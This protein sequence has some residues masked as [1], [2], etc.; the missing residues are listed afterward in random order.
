MN[1]LY[2][3][4]HIGFLGMDSRKFGSSLCTAGVDLWPCTWS[5]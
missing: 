2:L 3:K 5:C 4:F 1:P